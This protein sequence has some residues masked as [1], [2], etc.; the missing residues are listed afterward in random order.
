MKCPWADNC[1]FYHT[2]ENYCF[3]ED[4]DRY[5]CFSKKSPVNGKVVQEK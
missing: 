1:N 4:N 2:Y 3:D 5:G